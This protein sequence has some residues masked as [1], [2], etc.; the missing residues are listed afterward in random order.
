MIENAGA[1][2]ICRIA[3]RYGKGGHPR[4]I[5]TRE[6]TDEIRK[7]AGTGDLCDRAAGRVIAAADGYLRTEP[8]KYD[9]RDG[10]RLLYVSHEI[11]D[12]VYA[13]GFSYLVTGRKEYLERGKRELFAAL[14]FPDWHPYHD[15]DYG[16]MCYAAAFGYDWFYNDLSETERAFCREK[17]CEYGFGPALEDY[18]DLPR[19]RT[20]PWVQDDPGDNHKLINNG[21]I[22]L[23]ALAICDETD[24]DVCERVLDF[25]YRDDYKFIRAAYDVRDGSYFEGVSY[26]EYGM[27]HLAIHMTG[28]MTACGTIYDFIDWEGFRKTPYFLVLLCSNNFK[29]FCFSDGSEEYLCVSPLLWVGPAVGENAFAQLRIKRMEEGD[30]S[31]FD[32]MWYD[33]SATVSEANLPTDYGALGTSN[34]TF[35]SDWSDQSMFVG[36]HYGKNKLPHGHLDMGEFCVDYCNR[37]FFTDLGKDDYNLENYINCYRMRAEGHN[38]LVI[39]PSADFDQHWSGEAY[40]DEFVTGEIARVS[41][42]MSSAYSPA[43]VR[44]TL[45]LDKKTKTAT[46]TDEISCDAHD[47]I[48]WFG[49]TPAEADVQNDGKTAILTMDGVRL[50]VESVGDG[51]MYLTD[52]SPFPTSPKVPGQNENR[53]IRKL[54]IKAEGK[55]AYVISVKFMPYSDEETRPG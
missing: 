10:L 3:D 42:D 8:E 47:T 16:V 23:C 48:Y 52:A 36:I 54:A 26:W 55:S 12:R 46:V 22:S 45:S 6:K 50:R 34:A 9:L 53:G 25:A 20:Y 24:G 40:A 11:A 39:N 4:I 37:R 15:L 38:T 17:I 32:I 49:H 27:R 14:N 43:K 44:R 13:L 33:P 1:D 41:A 7:H 5:F 2:M 30:I 21:G 31:L 29:S 28:L 19:K 51:Q 35:R 18:L